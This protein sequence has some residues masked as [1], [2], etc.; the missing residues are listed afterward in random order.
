MTLL[1]LPNPY[2]CI[3]YT[4]MAEKL[5]LIVLKYVRL[6]PNRTLLN[7]NELIIYNVTKLLCKLRTSQLMTFA[8]QNRLHLCIDQ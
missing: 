4:H 1:Q 5:G 2:H 8:L 7:S 6:Y 3:G